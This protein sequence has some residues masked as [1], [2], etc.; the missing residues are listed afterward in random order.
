MVHNPFQHTPNIHRVHHNLFFHE[1]Y[2]AVKFASRV[3]YGVAVAVA[4]VAIVV[5]A[6]ML[7]IKGKKDKS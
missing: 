4:I 7:I 1:P 3:I 2:I 5:V 6:L